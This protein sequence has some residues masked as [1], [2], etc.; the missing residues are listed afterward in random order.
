MIEVLTV[1]EFV[2][3]VGEPE[4]LQIA[5][6]GGWNSADGRTLDEPRILHHIAFAAELI[7]GYCLARHPWLAGLA[8]SDVPGVI[9]GLAADIVRYRLRDKP[10]GT[11][12]VDDVVRKNYEDALKRLA[13]I[14]AGRLDLA[15]PAGVAAPAPDGPVGRVS[16]AGADPRTDR[17]LEGY[18]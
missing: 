17:L 6:T 16:T 12:Q 7:A 10:G 4:A 9:R 11:G 14:G 15:A 13:E 1:D 2:E 3:R 5:G 18:R 8:F